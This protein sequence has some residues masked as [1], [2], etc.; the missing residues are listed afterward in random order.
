MIAT[1]VIVVVAA[2]VILYLGWTGINRVAFDD[3]FSPFNMLYYSWIVP[4]LIRGL[5]LSWFE[6]EWNLQTFGAVG[7][8]TCSLVS[9]S[10]PAA[11]QRKPIR[12]LGEV[13]PAFSGI[14]K[15]L[16]DN[17]I[18]AFL[19]VLYLLIFGL[20]LYVEFITNP[21]GFALISGLAG[22]LTSEEAGYYGWGKTEGRTFFISLATS[23]TQFL[24][25][26]GPIFYLRFRCGG[27]RIGRVFFLTIASS[28]TLLGLM[29]LSKGDVVTPLFILVLTEYYYRR[30]ATGAKVALNPKKR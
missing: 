18:I 21:A 10:L 14:L 1:R 22:T 26:L 12:S 5:N 20:Y 16:Q 17:R 25:I 4:L 28:T 6:T 27:T 15:T 23:A 30:L 3:F 9:V 7:L 11:L 2:G 24:L 13:Q 8:V 29:K 19:L